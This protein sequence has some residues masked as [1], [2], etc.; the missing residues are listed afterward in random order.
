MY[1]LALLSW[2][3]TGFRIIVQV[4]KMN[5]YYFG[6]QQ[7]NDFYRIIALSWKDAAESSDK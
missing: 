2:K 3:K 4:L 5:Q 7:T 1:D 6:H